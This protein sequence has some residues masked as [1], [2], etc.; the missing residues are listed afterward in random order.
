MVENVINSRSITT[1]PNKT[2]LCDKSTSIQFYGQW[3]S[4]WA[5]TMNNIGSIVHEKTEHD[6]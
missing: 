6:F 3:R 2:I 5:K 4:P 1:R